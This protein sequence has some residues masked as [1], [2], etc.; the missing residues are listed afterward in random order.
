MMEIYRLRGRKKPKKFLSRQAVQKSQAVLPQIRQIVA[1]FQ[2]GEA[3]ALAFVQS[4]LFDPLADLPVI[5][6]LQNAAPIFAIGVKSR[7][8]AD[9]IKSATNL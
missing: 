2:K 3:P 8:N 1:A 4:S 7:R 9:N 5:V 6:G